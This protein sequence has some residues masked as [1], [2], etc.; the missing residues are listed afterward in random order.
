VV[1]NVLNYYES[2][3]NKALDTI[4]GAG[5]TIKGWFS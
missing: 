4:K 3:A 2:F 1:N 5:S